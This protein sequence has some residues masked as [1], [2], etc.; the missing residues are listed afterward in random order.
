MLPSIIKFNNLIS[1]HKGQV[2]PLFVSDLPTT[3]SSSTYNLLYTNSLHNNNKIMTDA[4]NPYNIPLNKINNKVIDVHYTFVKNNHIKNN[5][6][7]DA[8]LHSNDTGIFKVYLNEKKSIF[9]NDGVY[10]NKYM[11]KYID[12][13]N[14][15]FC[16]LT[17]LSGGKIKVSHLTHNPIDMNN[18]TFLSSIDL[19]N[20]QNNQFISNISF[21]LD[22]NMINVTNNKYNKDLCDLIINSNITTNAISEECVFH[23]SNNK[24]Y[25]LNFY[26]EVKNELI[27]NTD[28]AME[29]LEPLLNK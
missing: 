7:L 19:N 16:K 23:F 11:Q 25:D 10:N 1:P 14:N 5:N 4:L 27:L 12:V 24:K 18:F 21:E 26:D 28:L 6:D 15:H 13:L 29:I 20:K 17:R 2:M 9:F 3:L 8:V 22:E